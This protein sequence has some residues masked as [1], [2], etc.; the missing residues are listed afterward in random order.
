M[1][2]PPPRRAEAQ[3][4]FAAALLD[5]S[6]R[7]AGLVDGHGRAAP[8][9]FMVWRNT[10]RASLADALGAAFPATRRLMGDDYF[11]AA[12]LHYVERE[13][14]RSPLL[15]T[16]GGNFAD[17]IARLPGLAPYPFV[18]E[19]A[20][21]EFCRLTAYHAADAAPLRPEDLAA[22][23]ADALPTARFDAHPAAALLPLP[24]GGLAAWQKNADPPADPSPEP[25]ALVTRPDLDVRVTPLSA[26][27][28]D[29]AAP[30]L[31]GRPLGESAALAENADIVEVLSVLLREGAFCRVSVTSPT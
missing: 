17:A 24:A 27:A 8:E 31:A 1:A 7:V 2:E 9:R 23:A 4:A 16:Y 25:A 13:P 15:M 11:R 18:P 10:M 28:A 29:F 26:A 20:R 3:A 30:L 5:R 22:L 6:Q 14:P 12:A 21:L 19:V